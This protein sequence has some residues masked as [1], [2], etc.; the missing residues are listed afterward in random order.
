MALT[1]KQTEVIKMFWKRGYFRVEELP[2]VFASKGA[3]E[4]CMNS[5]R[6]NGLVNETD[7]KFFI[8]RKRFLE[9]QE[10]E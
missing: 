4:E 8:N 5:L 10:Q 6:L 7:F 3:R 9:L 1:T 2:L